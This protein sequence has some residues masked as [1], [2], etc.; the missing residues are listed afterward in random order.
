MS[1]KPSDIIKK[2]RLTEKGT[3]LSEK[4]NKY[5][6]HVDPRAN[7]IQIKD[8]IKQLFGKTAVAVNTCNYEGKKRRERRA[9]YGRRPSWKKAVVQL[10]EGESIDLA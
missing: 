4:E 10:K 7:K 8:A 6:F 3:I 2:I 5:V 9:D 1:L